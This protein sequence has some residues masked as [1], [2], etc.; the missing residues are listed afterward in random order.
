M[1]KSKDKINR[2][3]IKMFA[4]LLIFGGFWYIIRD[5]YA[6]IESVSV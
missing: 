1:P 4:K 2:K 5:E 6:V 3:Y